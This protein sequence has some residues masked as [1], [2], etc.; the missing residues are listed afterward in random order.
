[1]RAHDWIVLSALSALAVP[2]L[3]CHRNAP[4]QRNEAVNT[5][6]V[7]DTATVVPV[8]D[9]NVV[10]FFKDTAP[11]RIFFPEAQDFELKKPAQRQS[12]RAMIRKERE[13]WRATKPRDYQFLLRV[14]CFCPGTRGWQLMQVRG[15]QPLRAWDRT[16]KS[17]ALTDWNTLSIDALYDNL[18]RTADINGEV[19]IAFDPR[20]HFPAYIRTIV[21]PGPD[22]WSIIEVR[23]LRP[24]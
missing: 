9:R 24:I 7:R 3:G 4:G 6:V 13:L 12:L 5:V 8:V 17:V 14:D 16:G 1:M 20:W 22:A 15:N 21:L 10:A 23:A 19:R 11:S 18:E 2:S